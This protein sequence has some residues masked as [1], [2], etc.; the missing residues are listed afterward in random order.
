MTP[1]RANVKRAIS[2]H[3]TGFWGSSLIAGRSVLISAPGGPKIEEHKVVEEHLLV[4][5]DKKLH[6]I[7][8]RAIDDVT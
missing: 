5:F 4:Q 6:T 1:L 2:Y 7:T 8:R 3:Q